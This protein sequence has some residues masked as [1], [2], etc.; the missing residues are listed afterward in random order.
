MGGGG[1]GGGG[2]GSTPAFVREGTQ[3]LAQ[4]S[5]QLFDISRPLLEQGTSQIASLIRTGGPGANVPIINQAVSA[6]RG[7]ADR[8]QAAIGGDLV[9]S[10]L[11][12]TPRGVPGGARPASGG[13]ATTG[14]VTPAVFARPSVFANRLREQVGRTGSVAAGN[15]PTRAAAPLITTAIAS[16]LSG[17]RLASAGFQGG[18]SAL[19]TAARVGAQARAQAAAARRQ[20]AT[21]FG[22]N[23][24]RLTQAGGFNF[25]RDPLNNLFQRGQPPLEGAFLGQPPRP[26]IE[27]AFL[28]R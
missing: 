12:P 6:Q 15:I 11:V 23:L 22:Q 26:P 13:G 7:A 21:S 2:G 10:G 19:S 24:V 4:R 1:K 14:P 3:A 27:G 16:G 28:G 5:Q 25:L 20:A 8:T 18:L 17:G 9:R